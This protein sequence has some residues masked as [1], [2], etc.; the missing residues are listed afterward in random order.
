MLASRVY[1][2]GTPINPVVLPQI[3]TVKARFSSILRYSTAGSWWQAAPVSE[4]LDLRLPQR[5][6]PR[7]TQA[8]SLSEDSFL[9]TKT[10]T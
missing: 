1:E 6:V 5:N 4:N 10:A 9:E 2:T 7:R 3:T 8:R